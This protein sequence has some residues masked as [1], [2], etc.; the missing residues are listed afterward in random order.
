MRAFATTALLLAAGLA[1]CAP[2][3]PCDA[4]QTKFSAQL[5]FGRTIGTQ[6]EVSEQEWQDFLAATVTP[7]FSDGLT[8]TDTQGQ[9]RDAATGTLVRERSKVVTILIDDLAA[10]RPRLDAIADAYKR[11]F[12]QDAVGIVISPACVAFR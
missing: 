8:V 9:W 12:K 5:L 11:R 3:L 2:R 7:A 4:A 1:A 6:G 10:A